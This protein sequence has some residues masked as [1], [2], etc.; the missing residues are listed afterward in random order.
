MWESGGNVW[1]LNCTRHSCVAFRL[2]TW[3][4]SV[5]HAALNPT[6]CAPL[7]LFSLSLSLSF[8]VCS[9]A[10]FPLTAVC[11]SR[12]QR[13]L[14]DEIWANNSHAPQCSGP[15][16]RGSW[17]F[18]KSNTPQNNLL[19]SLVP[20]H[21]PLHA[22]G[23]SAD[24]FTASGSR[25]QEVGAQTKTG[26]WRGTEY[27]WRSLKQQECGLIDYSLWACIVPSWSWRCH[28]AIT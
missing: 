1:P 14:P 10:S 18:S 21:A 25:R 7:F 15:I 17:C 26:F 24:L 27:F 23:L 13:F 2:R 19:A 8:C 22:A 12:A 4:C 6:R 28:D 16:I 20:I 3:F 5:L 9:Y 11:S